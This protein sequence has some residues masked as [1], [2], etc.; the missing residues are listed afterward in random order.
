MKIE[1]LQNRIKEEKEKHKND[2]CSICKGNGYW[3]DAKGVVQT[4]WKCLNE[5]K[6]I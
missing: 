1:D 4:C 6:L 3:I 5:G 2:P